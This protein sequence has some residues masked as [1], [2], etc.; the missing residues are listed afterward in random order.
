MARSCTSR[1]VE[2]NQPI[3]GVGGSLLGTSCSQKYQSLIYGYFYLFVTNLM[4]ILHELS[5]RTLAREIKFGGL[6][7]D[8]LSQGV[9]S[10]P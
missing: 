1:L 2:K 10:Y 7:F 6:S 8:F 9:D 5:I 4:Q 3:T